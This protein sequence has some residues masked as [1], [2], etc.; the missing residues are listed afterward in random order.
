MT[1]HVREASGKILFEASLTPD[2]PTDL[3]GIVGLGKIGSKAGGDMVYRVVTR[4]HLKRLDRGVVDHRL[5]NDRVTLP[6]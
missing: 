4:D 5:S 3:P 1:G 6:D 2:R